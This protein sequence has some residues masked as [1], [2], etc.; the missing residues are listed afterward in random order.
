MKK[1]N[2]EKSVFLLIDGLEPFY[3]KRDILNI[4]V[5]S[6]KYENNECPKRVSQNHGLSP[7]KVKLLQ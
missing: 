7:R 5:I 1:C 4:Y 6:I 3:T 2:R